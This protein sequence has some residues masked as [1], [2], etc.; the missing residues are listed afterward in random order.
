MS[1]VGIYHAGL[2]VG[3]IER[4]IDFYC[5]LLGMKL[6]WRQSSDS[7][8]ISQLTG[9]AGTHLLVAYLRPQDSDGPYVELLQYIAPPGTPI[10]PT[11]NNPG[12][13]HVCFFV[14]DLDREYDRLVETGVKFVSEPNLIT[15]GVHAGSKTVYL[16]DPDGIRVELFQRG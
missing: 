10:D 2:T 1:V 3:D 15:A 8:Y 14:E 7:P 13:A 4:S 9:L 6:A 11:P 16:Y 12:T 5:D